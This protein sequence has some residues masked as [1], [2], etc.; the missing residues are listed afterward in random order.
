MEKKRKKQIERIEEK[1]NVV[2][3]ANSVEI[4]G[5]TV[6]WNEQQINL[7]YLGVLEKSKGL[8]DLIEVIGS[9][10]NYFRE[11]RVCVEIAGS[12]TEGDI[13]EEQCKKHEIS[14][15]V[16]FRGWISGAE[17]DR[18]I[19]KSQ[20]LILPSYTE[21]L[22]MSVLE[23]ISCGMPVIATD[24]GD[25]SEAVINGWNGFL[26]EPGDRKNM[27]AYIKKISSDKEL[28]MQFSKNAVQLSKEKFSSEVFFEKCYELYKSLISR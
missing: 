1:A 27:F 13:L 18:L 12:G 20:I 25:I 2:A 6:S 28:Y 4:T 23:A 16:R 24:V 17:K 3:I 8:N 7:L 11:N 21:G 15:L 26:F 9:N 22:P 10:Q 14:D 5:K 19:Q